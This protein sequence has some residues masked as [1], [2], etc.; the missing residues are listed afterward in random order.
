MKR[1]ALLSLIFCLF[2]PAL[3]AVNDNGAASPPAKHLKIA[4]YN[5]GERGSITTQFAANNGYSG[6]TWDIEPV[7]TLTECTAM[8]INWMSAGELL[9]VD[10][11]YILDDTADGNEL[12]AG[13]WSTLGNITGVVSAGADLPTYCDFSGNGVVF[14][15][16]EHAMGVHVNNY[17]YLISYLGYTNGQYY[18]SNAD[19]GLETWHGQADPWCSYAF[20]PRA[21]NGTLYY[22]AGPP[23]PLMVSPSE[24]SAYF[25]GTF[26]FSLFGDGLGGRDFVLLG[27]A[28][29]ISPPIMLPGGG[30]LWLAKDWFTT[31]CLQAALAGG[32]GVL[33]N[34]IGTLDVDGL[35]TAT[36]TL[37]GHCQLYEDLDLWFAWTTYNPFDFQSNTV[38]VTVTGAPPELE[39]Y[40]WDDG[41]S[42]NALG[43]T[44]G[45]VAAWIHSFDS[46]VGDDIEQVCSCFGQ[47]GSG[48]GPANGTDVDLWVWSDPNQDGEPS[49][50]L[51][52]GHGSGVVD[53][54]STNTFNH[55]NLDA[56]TAVTGLFFVGASLDQLVGVYAAPM[57][58]NTL[59]LGVS[60][61]GGAYTGSVYGYWDPYNLAGHP[62]YAMGAIGFDSAWMLRANDS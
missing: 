56:S 47:A 38:Q 60:F 45:G 55:Y 57:D 50:G 15:P 54:T 5:V 11:Y 19:L 9:N 46:G 16:G 62:I 48:N 32:W 10:A 41:T 26:T 35:A 42:E 37:P 4:D 2:V 27:S 7:T 20:F 34:F 8:D 36:M 13:A 6:N 28:T 14:G 40:L 30:L 61:F 49:D 25:G 51:V 12:N 18:Y 39:E 21:W 33:D 44:S 3:F 22:N 29:G 53:N 31:L 58:Q 24:I 23:P 1:L 43:W 17:L 52:L 59:G